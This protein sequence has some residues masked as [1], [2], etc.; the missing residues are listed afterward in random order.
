MFFGC[1]FFN[2]NAPR[3]FWHLTV[4]TQ[5][6]QYPETCFAEE[7][8]TLYCPPFEVQLP[9]ITTADILWNE[10]QTHTDLQN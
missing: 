7:K 6:R 1:M 2:R 8:C 3:Q 4:T 10:V 5:P 9:N